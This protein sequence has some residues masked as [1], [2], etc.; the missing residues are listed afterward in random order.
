MAFYSCMHGYYDIVYMLLY[1]YNV[2]VT[3]DFNPIAI[4]QTDL[5][6]GVVVDVFTQL[7]RTQWWKCIHVHRLMCPYI[8]ASLGYV[9][10]LLDGFLL[11]DGY[12]II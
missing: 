8:H 9:N 10:I 11:V 7:V 4:Q 1:M 3:A 6:L 5:Q 12:Y 2:A